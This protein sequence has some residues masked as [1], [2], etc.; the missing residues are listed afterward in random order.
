MLPETF[1]DKNI[2][3]NFSLVRI[4]HFSQLPYGS[5]RKVP[6]NCEHNEYCNRVYRII[7]PGSIYQSKT[8]STKLTS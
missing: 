8:E 1:A 2:T 3:C 7:F 6:K 5:F 4:Y